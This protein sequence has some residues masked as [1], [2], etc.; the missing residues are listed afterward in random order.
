MAKNFYMR[1]MVAGRYLKIIRYTRPLPG[2]NKVVRQA[3]TAATNAAQRYINIKN[4]AEKLQLLL[5]ANFDR[6]DACF[7]T[8]TFDDDNLPANRKHAQSIIVSTFRALKKEFR[9]QGRD[10]KYIYVVE[11]ES[12]S[13]APDAV[14][15]AAQP[16]EIAPWREREK[17][18]EMDLLPATGSQEPP[19]RFHVHGFLILQKEDYETV[20]A[21]W[22]YGHVYINPMRVNDLMTFQRLAN[23]ATKEARDND[24]PNGMRV[25]TPSLGLEQPTTEGHWCNDYEGIALP[26]GAEQ[27]DRGSAVNDIYGSSMEYLYCRMPRPQQPPQPYTGKGR[28]DR[29][30]RRSKPTE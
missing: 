30:K 26:Q 27:L 2:D 12:L 20:R 23:Y 13:T 7:C 16:W 10:M 19:T 1:T 24:L 28:I 21:L 11:G 22:P 17:W 14:P 9:R 18:A 29:R 25:Y 4:S 8:F 3:K 15:V 6:K 5:C